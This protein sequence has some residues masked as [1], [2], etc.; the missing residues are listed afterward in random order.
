[1]ALVFSEN[2]PVQE[3]TAF[4][5][6]VIQIS[7]ALGINPNWLMIVM[8]SES[9]LN[10]RAY[11]PIPPYPVGL[12]Q[13]AQQTA[14]GLGTS[15]QALLNMSRLEQLDY[16]Y[17]YFRP[18]AGK[19]K[20]IYDL[21]LYNFLPSSVG[22]A[23]SHIIGSEIS[24]SYALSVAQ[25]NPPFNLNKDGKITIGEFKYFIKNRYGKYIN[26]GGSGSNSSKNLFYIL[27]G[28]LIFGEDLGLF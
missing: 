24:P 18:K 13:F 19:F 4:E 23:D 12:I 6:K 1:M 27:A 5:N 3:R 10:P 14:F 16:V 8:Q 11:N 7:R 28:I 15:P 25:S 9:G 2:I 22:Y 21:Y 20:N 26:Q 17:K